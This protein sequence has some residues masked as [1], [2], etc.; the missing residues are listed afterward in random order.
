MTP[1]I[2]CGYWKGE[3]QTVL[4]ALVGSDLGDVLP[5][6]QDLAFGDLVRRVAHQGV[7]ERRLPGA[8]RPHDRVLLVR[9]H[10]EVDTLHD[11]GAVF[12]CDVQVLDLEQCQLISVLA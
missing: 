7:G 9:V 3:E 10:G 6:E 4:S 5:V 11:L 2:A 12:E 8:V 1:G